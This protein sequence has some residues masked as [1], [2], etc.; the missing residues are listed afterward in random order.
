VA[1]LAG[2]GRVRVD[3]SVEVARHHVLNAAREYDVLWLDVGQLNP[4][5]E[6]V[7]SD[8]EHDLVSATATLFNVGVSV[9]F[10]G[11]D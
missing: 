5:V 1:L 7:V 4:I 8:P 9:V 10:L 3:L 2:E 6:Q 11:F